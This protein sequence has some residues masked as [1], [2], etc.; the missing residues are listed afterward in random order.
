MRLGTVRLTG[1]PD[2]DAARVAPPGLP[3][4]RLDDTLVY[5]TEDDDLWVSAAERARAS[6]L[7]PEERPAP[8]RP[9]DLRL[10]TQ[11]GRVFQHEHPDVPVLVDKGRYLII[12]A[13][14]A[15]LPRIA[16]RA[17]VCFRVEPLPAEGVVFRT[18]PRAERAP[19][20]HIEAL[21]GQVSGERYLEVLGELVAFGTRHS[22]STGFGAAAALARDRLEELGYIAR[23]A[24][25]NVGSGRCHNV[26]ADR[27]GSGEPAVRGVVML[28][29][30][31][32]SVNL[33]GGPS[34][35]APG[36]DD[37]A[38]GA[39]G[40]LEIARVLAGHQTHDD[41]RLILFGGEEQGLH[42]STQ[43]VASL[44][45]T[46]AARIKAVVNM[47]MIATL[48]TARPTVLLEGAALSKGLID[49]LAAAAAGYT[50]LAVQTSLNPFNSD[51]V[52]FIDASIPAVLTIEGSD[53]ANT[54]IHT[55]GD[56]LD[57]INTDLAL[58]IL[59]MN[60]ATL[61]QAADPPTP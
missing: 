56:T 51:H 25:I 3:W 60:L 34:A 35:P 27:L 11:V 14:D 54:H 23:L 41:I 29:A 13:S 57:H 42:G 50:E 28:T 45:P 20:P 49:S 32:D 10:V 8:A 17:E 59:R 44:G 24:P 6:G 61:T 22:L 33:A 12:A 16:P 47:D 1:E 58:D 15:L 39:A 18:L 30:H 21:T 53:G 9:A 38:S 46:E 48:N 31:L 19:V 55:A 7:R 40:L 37:N 2:G 52:P 5:W 4:T 26:I 36:A 43:Y